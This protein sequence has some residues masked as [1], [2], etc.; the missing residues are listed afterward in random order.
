VPELATLVEAPPEGDAWIHETKF[1]GYRILLALRAG[2][3]RLW[4][5][6]GQDWTARFPSIAREAERLPAE[7]AWL[8]GELVKAGREGVSSFEALQGALS[9]GDATG[10]SYHVFD[11]LH[12]DGW[13][14]TGAPLLARKDAVAGLLSRRGTSRLR[15]T[16][17]V[18]GQGARVLAAAC[19]AGLEGIVSKAAASPYRPGRGLDWRKVRCGARQEFVIAGYVPH[20]ADRLGIGALLLGTYEEGRLRYAGKVG[21][22]F[23]ETTRRDLRRRLDRLARASSPFADAPRTRD[24]VRWARPVLVGEVAFTEWTREGRLRHPS[25]LG[26]REDKPAADVR[27][28]AR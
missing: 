5:R 21:T 8:D 2:R 20:S 26:L 1:D 10:L 11:A 16:S 7:A 23:S 19:R 18:R 3:A 14:L 17:H 27:R 13:D 28:E 15:A 6:G 4:T 22:G 12:L 25:F 24:P 9:D